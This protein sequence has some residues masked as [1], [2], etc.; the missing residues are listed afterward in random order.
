M[1]GKAICIPPNSPFQF[2]NLSTNTKLRVLITTM[3]CWPGPQEAIKVK[4]I[5]EASSMSTTQNVK[6]NIIAKL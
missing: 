4:R 2:R 1:P 3:P 5:W 6:S